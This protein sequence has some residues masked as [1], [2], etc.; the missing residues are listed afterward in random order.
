MEK[1]FLEFIDVLRDA[2]VNIST[3]EMLT[4]FQALPHVPVDDKLI[5]KQA[6]QT[7]L[8][9]DYTDIPVFD[10][11]FKEFFEGIGGIIGNIDQLDALRRARSLSSDQIKN[12]ENSLDAF[13]DSLAENLIFEKNPQEIF[14]LFIEEL[15][16][17]AASGG[18]GMAIFQTS[19]SDVRS[20]Y[21]QG[22]EG[23][24]R[25]DRAELRA[26]LVRMIE[27]KMNKRKVGREIRDREE[28]LLTGTFI[29]SSPMKSKRCASWS[30]GSARN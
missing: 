21:G 22:Q 9:K 11:C 23:Q 16:E 27:Q 14:A 10:R 24:E 17:S 19:R 4:L 3:D 20:Q 5:F 28:Y 2:N 18:S 25:D 1:K 7:S 8:I 15:Q 12:I 26:I 29:S 30:E 6:L 13:L